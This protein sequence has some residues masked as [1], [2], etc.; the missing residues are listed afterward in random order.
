MTKDIDMIQIIGLMIGVYI[1]TRMLDT[2]TTPSVNAAARV[3]AVLTMLIDIFL[4][5]MLFASSTPMP[6]GIGR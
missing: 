4:I 2:A 1:F 3:A 5:I 6:P